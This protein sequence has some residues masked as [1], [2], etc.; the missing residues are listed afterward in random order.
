M[1]TYVHFFQRD[2][3]KEVIML[4]CVHN[5][6][7]YYFLIKWCV[8]STNRQKLYHFTTM[9]IYFSEV[10][11]FQFDYWED[12]DQQHTNLWSPYPTPDLADATTLWIL[13]AVRS[14]NKIWHCV[15]HE[16]PT[17]PRKRSPAPSHHL[18]QLQ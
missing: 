15:L 13:A 14:G 7:D 11:L 10:L 18:R 6:V 3:S 5:F 2:G 4:S 12:A 9:I 8:T 17:P 16:R 1:I